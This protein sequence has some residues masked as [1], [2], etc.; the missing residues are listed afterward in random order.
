MKK[1]IILAFVLLGIIPAQAKKIKFAV[2]MNTYTINPAGIHMMSDF[3]AILGL[4]GGD[5][6][7]NTLQLNQEGTSTIYSV[8][9]DIPAKRKYEFKFINGV[10]GYEAEFVPD[11]SRVGYFFN[12][13]RWLYLDS[14]KNDTTF[15]GA[16]PFSGNAP[17][18]KSLIRFLVDMSNEASLSPNGIHV[19]GNFQTPSWNYDN[20]ILYSF[21]AGVYE[22][23]A[24]APNGNYQY[25]FYN[26]NLSIN[27]EGVPFTCATSNNRTH[28]L[29]KDTILPVVCYNACT[30][31]SLAAV[32]EYSS[33]ISGIKMYPNPL[34]YSSTMEFKLKNTDYS[35]TLMDLSGR[36]LK[37]YLS[38][39]GEKVEI[40]KEDLKSGVYFISVVNSNNAKST[41]KLIV[42]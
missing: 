14:L 19:A 35:V 16:I 15:V 36:I 7:P 10:F 25:R 31:C 28:N 26:G 41:S 42:Q 2:D 33:Q 5:W 32:F 21:G 6:Q 18:G 40:K 34:V 23:I 13:N 24:Y 22:T 12:D 4:A 1:I 11:Q 8:I 39:K 17:A 20:N 3:Q 27:S 38:E 9:V 29:Q 30:S 37:T